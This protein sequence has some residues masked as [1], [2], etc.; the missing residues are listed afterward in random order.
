MTGAFTRAQDP[1]L[2][3][4]QKANFPVAPLS[5]Q[6]LAAQD[7]VFGALLPPALHQD[8]IS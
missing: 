7:F 3:N 6:K 4:A 5:F 2:D 1:V 8:G